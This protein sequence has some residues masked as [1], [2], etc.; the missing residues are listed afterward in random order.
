MSGL[1]GSGERIQNLFFLQN[2]QTLEK[3]YTLSPT[4]STDVV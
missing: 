1:L 2:S 3:A 4:A